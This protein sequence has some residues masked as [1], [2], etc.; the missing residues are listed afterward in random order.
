MHLISQEF[1]CVGFEDCKKYPTKRQ[2]WSSSIPRLTASASCF[3]F[4]PFFVAQSK[5][6]NMFQGPKYLFFMS[7]DK[8]VS[9]DYAKGCYAFS[10]IIIIA[11]VSFSFSFSNCKSQ[12]YDYN[13]CDVPNMKISIF[14]A[15]FTPRM[16]NKSIT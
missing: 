9:V 5:W 16:S 2:F 1:V 10:F 6:Y 8:M 4:S 7:K 11:L 13:A 12:L 3:Y 15:Y 14:W